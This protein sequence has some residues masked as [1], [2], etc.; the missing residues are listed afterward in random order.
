MHQKMYQKVLQNEKSTL[1]SKFGGYGGCDTCPN[2]A[3][4]NSK[5]D[6]DTNP[7]VA[8]STN[9]VS[10]AGD[11]SRSSWG[12]PFF[13]A[14]ICPLDMN[15]GFTT[16]KSCSNIAA[17]DFKQAVDENLTVAMNTNW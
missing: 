17:S 14:M 11:K 2:V 1:N 9:D 7:M 13:Q 3:T 16:I 8:T 12:T 6:V 10:N 5:E 4:W 15:D